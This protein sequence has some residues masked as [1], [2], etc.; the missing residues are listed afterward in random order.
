MEIARRIAAELPHRPEWLEMARANLDRWSHLNANSPS[1]LRCYSEWRE[2]LDQPVESICAILTEPSDNGQR[3]R[4]NSPFA[5]ALA[6]SVVW[7]IKER[8][9]HGQIPA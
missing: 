1:L 9:R 8:L 3:L 4:Q 2:I 7:D 6:P 5:G